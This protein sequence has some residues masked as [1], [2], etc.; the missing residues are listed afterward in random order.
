M[1]PD[2]DD[3]PPLGEGELLA[4]KYRVE[5]VL[6]V[7]GVGVVVSA[8]HE[9][10]GQRVALKFLRKSAA[11]DRDSKERF[12]REARA[13][14]RL[15]SQH[16]IRVQDVGTLVSGEPYMVME[17]LEGVDFATL[18]GERGRLPIAE[19]VSYVLQA[20]EALAEAHAAGVIHRDLKPENLFLTTGVDRQPFVKVL[21]F[22]L[23]K[24]M[25][26][27]LAPS[28]KSLTGELVMGTPEYMSPEQVRSTH[29]VDS[30]ADIWSVGVLLY[31]LIGGDLPFRGASLPELITA[32]LRDPPRPL[33][34][35]APD[36]PA[37]L[38]AVIEKC[39]E[40]DADKRF[41]K[42]SRLAA[43]LEPF[44]GAVGPASV[45]VRLG[46]V[47]PSNAPPPTPAIPWQPSGIPASA[48]PR[49][50]S[51]ETM[52][53]IE[54]PVAKKPSLG[55]L[56]TGRSKIPV[57]P[58]AF[59]GVAVLLGV[60]YVM[61][62]ALTAPTLPTTS[63]VAEAPP[64]VD[65][66]P[67]SAPTLTPPTTTSPIPSS[68]SSAANQA[69]PPHGSSVSGRSPESTT[70]PP[71]HASAAPVTTNKRPH[72]AKDAGNDESRLLETR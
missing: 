4:E 17:L 66:A 20:C 35:L 49:V 31:E 42:I 52:A 40:K 71:P 65:A 13:V 10:L 61:V 30:R 19:A 55:D 23:V 70:R 64:F 3:L 16:A 68:A 67:S 60:G 22:G 62:R 26:A 8:I 58:I 6:G 47:Q 29:D 24:E 44:A 34:E 54:L 21:D 53:Q 2:D 12:L 57:W 33:R 15:K 38:V 37:D 48:N 27:Q 41:T 50:A 25:S 56:P 5:R 59:L 1:N 36:A 69:P 18:L 9:T 72:G 43:A 39:L 51:A 11:R 28:E 32:V 45:G 63:V 7:G 14:V 46:L